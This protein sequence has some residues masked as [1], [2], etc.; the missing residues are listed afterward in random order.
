MSDSEQP[1][2]SR[3]GVQEPSILA[4]LPRARPQRASPRRV[5]KAE[6]AGASIA[7]STKPAAK[8]AR[9]AKPKPATKAR[10][11]AR[12]AMAARARGDAHD[13]KPK[14]AAKAARADPK[15]TTRKA[16]P[17]RRR[18]PP[19]PKQGYE[20]LEEPR[21]GSTVHPPSGAEVVESIARIFGELASAGLKAGGQALKDALGPLRRP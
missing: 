17:Q 18:E 13:L 6:K 3:E 20:P 5:S 8:A 9:V 11:D 12:Q 15:R 4:A 10:Q 16:A 1:A 14:P 19:A 21:H 2:E 7:R